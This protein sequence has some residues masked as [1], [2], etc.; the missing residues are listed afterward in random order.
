MKVKTE[1]IKVRNVKK[2]YPVDV[3]VVQKCVKLGAKKAICD[4]DMSDPADPERV[5]KYAVEKLGEKW[6]HHSACEI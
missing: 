2:S 5:F 6:L 1:Q 3:Q 4:G